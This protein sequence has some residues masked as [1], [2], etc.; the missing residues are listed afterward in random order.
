MI[1]VRTVYPYLRVGRHIPGL[2]DLNICMLALW[3]QRYQDAKGKLWREI[4]D[5]KYSTYCPNIFC[6]IDR[7]SSPFYKGVMWD[8]AATKMGLRW[9]VGNG[10]KNRFW[11]DQWFGSCS[12]AIQL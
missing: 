12:L 11:E 8:V 7:N 9:H 10:E 2:R 5:F 3:V 4:V 1:L 6:C